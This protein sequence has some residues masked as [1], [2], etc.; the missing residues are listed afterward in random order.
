M[1]C[2]FQVNW[3]DL[4]YFITMERYKLQLFLQLMTFGILSI[5]T[6]VTSEHT[7]VSYNNHFIFFKLMRGFQSIDIVRFSAANSRVHVPCLSCA[8]VVGN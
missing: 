6:L 7:L 2:V 1:D 3:R 5:A 8:Q 4:S